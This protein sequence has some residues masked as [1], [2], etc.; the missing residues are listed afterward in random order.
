MPFVLSSE[1]LKEDVGMIKL[2]DNQGERIKC[3]EDHGR[4]YGFGHFHN[5][6]D[7]NTGHVG[8]ERNET[9]A[10]PGGKLHVRI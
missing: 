7:P 5:A 3:L 1:K 10:G 9:N 8:V 6:S 4:R 2:I